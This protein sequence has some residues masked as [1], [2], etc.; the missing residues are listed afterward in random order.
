MDAPSK[1]AQHVCRFTETRFNKINQ[2][3][4]QLTD[5]EFKDVFMN[6]LKEHHN[7][8]N[9]DNLLS[10]FRFILILLCRGIRPPTRCR[11]LVAATDIT[12]S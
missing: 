2:E 4:L 8:D 3:N 9:T 6:L 10:H 7:H 11:L 1:T 12:N 5:D